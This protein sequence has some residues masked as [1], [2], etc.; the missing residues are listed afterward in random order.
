[1]FTYLLYSLISS[2]CV[3]TLKS[4]KVEVEEFF[5]SVNYVI[6]SLIEEGGGVREINYIYAIL[7][8]TRPW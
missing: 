1:M 6:N 7:C 2:W 8:P 5:V 3:I 4:I